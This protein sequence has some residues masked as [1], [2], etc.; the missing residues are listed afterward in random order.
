VCQGRS[1]KLAQK[2][3]ISNNP[4]FQIDFCGLID[5][6]NLK[7]KMQYFKQSKEESSNIRNKNCEAKIK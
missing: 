3:S 7:L 4:C 2:E 6:L 5:F 1:K